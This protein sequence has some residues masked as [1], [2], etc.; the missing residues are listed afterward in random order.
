M[1]N[2]FGYPYFYPTAFEGVHRKSGDRFHCEHRAA[3]QVNLR[4]LY[5]AFPLAMVM[6]A[7]A[8][9]HAKDL[10]RKNLYVTLCAYAVAM[11]A[12]N[13][14]PCQPPHRPTVSSRS[15]WFLVERA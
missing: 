9:A 6:I 11:T 2:I 3:G 5:P 13:A 8:Y 1:N 15:R 14:T 7:I 12:V 4:Y 10:S